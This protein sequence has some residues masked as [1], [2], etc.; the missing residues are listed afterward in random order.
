MRTRRAALRIAVALLALGA[1]LALASAEPVEDGDQIGR[2]RVTR[3]GDGIELAAPRDRGLGLGLAVGG[4]ALAALGATL[5]AAGRRGP[6][7]AAL[8]AGLGLAAVG[9]AGAFGTTRVRANRVELVREGFGGRAERWPRAA[10]AAVEVTRRAASAEDFKRPGTH[11]WD[12]RL[13]GPDGA[14]LPVGFTLRSEADARSL[15]RALAGALGLPG[16]EG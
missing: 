11:P 9:A 16:A 12:V 13:L 2:Y 14:R 10:I 15:A 3:S 8:V 1:P 6:G 7:V 4:A 5:V